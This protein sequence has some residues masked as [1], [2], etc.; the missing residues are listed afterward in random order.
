M[1][2]RPRSVHL[3]FRVRGAIP[4]ARLRSLVVPPQPPKLCSFRV[5]GSYPQ[6]PVARGASALPLEFWQNLDQRPRM[7]SI[8]RIIILTIISTIVI[9]IIIF[10]LLV[11]GKP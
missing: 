1:S 3:F 5:Y 10:L 6:P 7:Y 2:G 11:L 8:I 4:I 9:V